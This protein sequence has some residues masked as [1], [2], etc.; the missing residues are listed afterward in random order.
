[1]VCVLTAKWANGLSAA[2]P[3]Q[4]YEGRVTHSARRGRIILFVGL[5]ACAVIAVALEGIVS[6]RWFEHRGAPPNALQPTVTTKVLTTG[7]PTLWVL[8]IGVSR[9]GE[10]SLNL[11]FAAA[12]ARAVANVLARQRAGPLYYEVNTAVLVDAEVTRT[13]ILRMLDEFLGRAAPIDVGVIYLAGHGAHDEALDNYYFLPAAALAEKPHIEGLDMGDFNRQLRLLHRNLRQLVVILD[14]CHAGAVAAGTRA[15]RLGE[16]LAERL[17][18]AEGLYVLAAAKS[19]EQSREIAALGHGAFTQALLDGLQG[20]AADADGLVRVLGLA[21]YTARVVP[22]LTEKGQTP[23]LSIVGEDLA[24][25]ADPQRFAQ[26]TPPPLPT[27]LA[28]AAPVAQRERIAIMHFENLRPDPQHDWMQQALG[29]QF[30]TTLHQVP[31]FDVYDERMVRF[32]ARGAADPIEASR[33][34]DMAILVNGTYWVHNNAISITAHVKSTNP[35]RSIASAEIDGPLEQFSELTGQVVVTLLRQMQVELAPGETEQLLRRH[36]TDLAA[37][38]LLFDAERPAAEAGGPHPTPAMGEGPDASLGLWLLVRLSVAATSHAADNAGPE[39]DLSATLEGYR[40]AFEREDPEALA[41]YY[42]EF[43]PAQRAALQRYFD[44]ADDL[45]IEFG[46][47]QIAMIGDQAAVSFNREDHF[48][49]HKSG[50]SQQVV[51]RVTKLFVKRA[52]V[53]QIVP[54]Q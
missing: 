12:D 45:R 53:W 50:E 43:S 20:A 7:R 17:P 10:P 31:R 18:P 15:A 1:M 21:S 44:N 26:I 49:D 6:R 4:E 41:H 29:E 48:V 40:Q 3:W 13:S 33:R 11:R 38:K 28:L 32:L 25:A 8:A 24:L 47:I 39:A 54:E 51:V 5:L 52:A 19:G 42:A 16:D 36:T 27:P 30:V 46:D 34:A 35:L 23:Y 37:R 14:T 22:Q 9:Y 2:D